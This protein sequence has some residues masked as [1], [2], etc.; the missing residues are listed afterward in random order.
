MVPGKCLYSYAAIVTYP[1]PKSKP[2]IS[3]LAMT[4]FGGASEGT[5]LMG[6]YKPT[7]VAVIFTA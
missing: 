3:E 7:S 5:I 1:D 6:S 4:L 2:I